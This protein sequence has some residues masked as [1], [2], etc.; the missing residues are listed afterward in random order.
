[1][2]V[3]SK[4]RAGIARAQPADHRGHFLRARAAC[5]I[6]DHQSAYFLLHALRSELMEVV[7]AA[8][9]EIG[10]AGQAIFAPAAVGIHRMLQVDNHLKAVVLQAF[11]GLPRHAQIFFR[12]RLE[13]VQHIQQP[14]LD[15][16]HGNGNPQPMANHELHIGPLLHLHATAARAAKQGKLHR[17]RIHRAK[18]RRQ[19]RDKL[20]RAGKANLGVMQAKARHALQQQ[21]RI[22]H[23]DV[24]VRL[25]HAVAQTGIEQLDLGNLVLHRLQQPVDRGMLKRRQALKI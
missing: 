11:N 6:A 5:R 14:R 10:V 21:N 7:E 12:R 4:A 24:E 16:N 2:P 3:K 23:G 15:H 20:V 25:L 22:G 19:V 13:R 1:M 9:M 17:S 8:R 18:R